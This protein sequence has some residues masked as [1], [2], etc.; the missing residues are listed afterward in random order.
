MYTLV[1]TWP[2]AL[3]LVL[4]GIHSHTLYLYTHMYPL[5]HTDIV[6]SSHEG[7]LPGGMMHLLWIHMHYLQHPAPTQALLHAFRLP[8]HP[9]PT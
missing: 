7:T 4:A 2:K 3:T 5:V 9:A 6:V 8:Q 1:H